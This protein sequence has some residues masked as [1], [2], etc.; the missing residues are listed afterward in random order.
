[1]ALEFLG[2]ADAVVFRHELH[3][4]A[5]LVR[6][7]QLLRRDADRAALRRVLDRVADDVDQDL[8]HMRLVHEEE[9]CGHTVLGRAGEVL[10]PDLFGEER[11]VGGEEILRVGRL[12]GDDDLVAFDAGHLEHA[13][14]Y[15]KQMPARGLDVAQ[16]FPPLRRVCVLLESQVCEADDGVHGGAYV[17]AHVEEKVRLRL[18][19]GVGLGESLFELELFFVF[20]M[21]EGV[22]VA[23]GENVIR[24]PSVLGEARDAELPVE[25]G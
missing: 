14:Q 19:G 7:R 12:F 1:M 4:A 8:L 13:V 6:P 23:E 11:C 2:H 15:F 16:I 9:G 17:V 24:L 3:D 21:H 22:D 18:I 25:G 5:F 20:L 10:L